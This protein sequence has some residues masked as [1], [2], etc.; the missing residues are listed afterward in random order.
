MQTVAEKDAEIVPASSS[1]F[2]CFVSFFFAKALSR[3]QHVIAAVDFLP[4]RCLL[5]VADQVRCSNLG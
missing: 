1:H 5:V 4:K 3:F 2:I